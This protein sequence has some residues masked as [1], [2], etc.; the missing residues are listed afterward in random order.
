MLAQ[1]GMGL[2]ELL[3]LKKALELKRLKIKP[4]LQPTQESR[5]HQT[6]STFPLSN[7][8]IFYFSILILFVAL[9]IYF[10]HQ[11]EDW[12]YSLSVYYVISMS[13]NLVF[14][15]LNFFIF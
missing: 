4:P 5:I 1:S 7:E 6:I 11:T 8:I 9:S 15:F 13:R 10:T 14:H 12:D 2:S 3:E